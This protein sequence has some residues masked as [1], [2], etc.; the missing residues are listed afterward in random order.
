M[1][2]TSYNPLYGF[3]L[4]L[5][6]LL[7][8]KDLGQFSYFTNT[9]LLQLLLLCLVV[10]L[11]K[12]APHSSSFHVLQETA[13]MVKW[14]GGD[15]VHSYLREAFSLKQEMGG[16]ISLLRTRIFAYLSLYLFIYLAVYIVDY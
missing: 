10:Q 5:W 14:G 6:R 9:V 13:A 1:T 16:E 7:E 15:F 3:D 12:W 11:S 4:C 2:K 8:K